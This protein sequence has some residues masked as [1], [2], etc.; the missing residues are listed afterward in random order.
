[1]FVQH[2]STAA[3]TVVKSE[4]KPRKNIQYKDVASAVSRSDA[5]E[6]LSD[7]IPKT[8]TYKELKARRANGTSGQTHISQIPTASGSGTG[9]DR[10]AGQTTLTSMNGVLPNSPEETRARMDRAMGIDGGERSII[11][12]TPV[13]DD[14][15]D[16]DPD[17]QLQMESRTAYTGNGDV[18]MTN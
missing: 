18:S 2:L 6:F 4:R 5:L 9:T 11:A 10:E 17:A 8:I 14:D 16:A 3:H 7:T 13:Q 12:P 15:E 1:M